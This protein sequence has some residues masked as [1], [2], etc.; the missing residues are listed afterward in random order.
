L[1]FTV[2]VV[3]VGAGVNEDLFCRG[4]LGRGL[5]GRYGYVGGVL[6]TSMLFGLLH[7]NPPHVVAA[8]MMGVILHFAYL[9]ARSLWI[10][11]GLHVLNNA[12]SVLTAPD[13]LPTN[14]ELKKLDDVTN[15]HPLGLVLASCF[16]L[17]AVGWALYSG[18]SRLVPTASPAPAWHPPYPGVAYP[19]ADSGTVVAHPL[20]G[21]PAIGLVAVALIV[22]IGVIAQA[23]VQG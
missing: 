20:P 18:R 2:L 16:L 13:L 6:L 19:P 5:V 14:P 3:A 1:W 10:P 21:G 17:L 22:F 8:A 23:L 12:A 9:T 11:I 7:I 4:F 15:A